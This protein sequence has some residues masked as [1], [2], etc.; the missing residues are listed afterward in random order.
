MKGR[1]IAACL[2]AGDSSP[3]Q[4]FRGRIRIGQAVEYS[5]VPAF[6][7]LP[8]LPR[9]CRVSQAQ[10]ELG[11]KIVRRKKTLKLV[12]LGSVGI[13]NLNRW[14]PLGAKAIKCFWLLLDVY[15]HRQIVVIDE[16]FDARIRVNL[17]L[18]PGTPPSHRRCTK[19]QQQDS[20]GSACLC[21]RRIDVFFPPN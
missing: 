6:R 19:I 13:Q 12:S 11:K 5:V 10:F 18:Q 7:F 17:G 1:G 14:R 2:V 3:I 21:Q 9:K 15:L 20:S 8:L 16:F 4:R